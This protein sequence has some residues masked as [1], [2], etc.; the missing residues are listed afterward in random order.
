MIKKCTVL[1]N[2]APG[3][4]VLPVS[5]ECREIPVNKEIK[6][7]SV[8]N[9][10]PYLRKGSVTDPD[11]QRSAPHFGGKVPYGSYLM[12]PVPKYSR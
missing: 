7:L 11:W 10:I 9:N 4:T 5:T 1:Q 8:Q 3:V 6:K 2:S 12:V